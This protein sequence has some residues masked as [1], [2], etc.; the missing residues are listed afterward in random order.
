MSIFRTR[1]EI[2]SSPGIT[3]F[4]TIK[5]YPCPKEVLKNWIC[6]PGLEELAPYLIRG[7]F[8]KWVQEARC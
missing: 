7:D 6:H 4:S 1:M 5:H 3:I 8:T 2:I